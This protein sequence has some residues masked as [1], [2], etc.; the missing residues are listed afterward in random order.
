MCR[1]IYKIL[2]EDGQ[3]YNIQVRE[4]EDNG[5]VGCS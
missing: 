5:G 1:F 3:G 4:E 2:T